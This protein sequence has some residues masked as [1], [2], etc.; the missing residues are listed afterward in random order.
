ML[1]RLVARLYPKIVFS[2]DTEATPLVDELAELALK[3]NPRVE[4]AR[5][6]SA[7]IDVITGGDVKFA[8]KPS[9]FCGS[10][11]WR[12]LVLH[13][14]A[15]VGRLPKPVRG[16]SRGLSCRRKCLPIHVLVPGRLVPRPESRIQHLAIEL[17]STGEHQLVRDRHWRSCSRRGR[18]NRNG[19]SLGFGQAAASG[20][21][22][23]GGSPVG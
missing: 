13:V 20:V 5:S 3:I 22:A 12:A 6:T 15:T 17:G 16:W 8:G 14:S 11:G 7:D 9:I 10:D 4:I 2:K 21:A 19:I 23:F 18:G 1:T